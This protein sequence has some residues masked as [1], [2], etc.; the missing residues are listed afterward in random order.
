LLALPTRFREHL[1]ALPKGLRVAWY[2]NPEESLTA[3]ANAEV[4]WFDPRTA[5]PIDQLLEAAPRLRWVTSQNVGVDRLPLDEFRRRHIR[6]TNA[7][8]H[9]A[10]PIAE[11]VVMALLA[12]AKGLP[13]L[14]HAQDREEWLNAPPRMNEVAGLRALVIGYGGIGRA[15][16]DRF[17]GLG[18][19]TIGVRTRARPPRILGPDGWRS[20]LGE[21]D[22]VVVTA[23]FTP[24]T[25]HLLGAEELANM[26][27]GAWLANVA[28][29]P[30]VDTEALTG[31]LRTGRLGGA[32]LDVTDPEPLPPGHPLWQM[33]NVL[34][35]PHSSW[36][37]APFAR[38]TSDFFVANLERYRSG[39]RLRNL[40]RLKSGY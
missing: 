33:P 5:A 19:D 12:W 34:V 7:A 35:T 4:L 32:Y 21:F 38:R 13:A 15:I 26:K 17:R 28:R 3:V 2:Q 6:L 8:G 31:A 22:V 36:A 9:Y 14:V 30:M 18:I 11:Y 40:V 39:R 16:G 1:D 24:Q 20:R 10:I 37:S 27:P 29:G 25:W 23:P